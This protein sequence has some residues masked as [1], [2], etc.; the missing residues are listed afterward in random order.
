MRV[1]PTDIDFLGHMNNG[2]YLS[3]A[4]FG[5]SDLSVRCGLWE[6]ARSRGWYSVVQN[7]TIS[8]RL[9]LELWKQYTLETK[10]VGL[11][12]RSIYVEQR[13]VLD[14]QIAAQMYVRWRFLMRDGG[15]VSMDEFRAV[16][17][18]GERVM[19]PPAWISRWGTE[20]ALPSVRAEAPSVW[21]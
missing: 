12:A 19:E 17:G 8:Y 15:P 3:L 9:S 13:F 7:A 2:V 14:G 5:R 4:D 20:V 16:S 11:D 10:I 18:I 1:R 6:Q 21:E